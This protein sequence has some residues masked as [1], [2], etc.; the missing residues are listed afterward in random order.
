MTNIDLINSAEQRLSEA[1]VESARLDA[2]VLLAH[3]L[4]VQR[5]DLYTGRREE[6]AAEAVGRFQDCVRRRAEG[7]PVAYITGIKEFWSIPIRV[8]QEVLIPRPETELIVE[9]SLS[10]FTSDEL[11]ILDLCTGSGCVAAALAKE[12]PGARFVVTDISQ[13]ALEMARVNLAFAPGRVEFC[14][15]DLF[16]PLLCKEGQGEVDPRSTPPRPSP[17]KG[18]G[19]V[20]DLITANPPYIPTGHRDM[21]CREITEHEPDIA[22]YGGKSG[23][24]FMA[25]IIEDAAAFLKPG[26]WL[27]MEMGLGQ[28]DKLK[29]MADECG[30]YSDAVISK[31]LAGIERVISLKKEQ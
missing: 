26:G 1:D 15:G 21:L 31:D 11:K 20:F 2:E 6:P 17:Y 27:V 5:V 10:I 23:L 13:A 28:A 18:E 8:T 22:L 25:R 24:D 30:G 7:C 16:S 29:A 4:G 9:R 19:P 14:Q 3:T 12:L